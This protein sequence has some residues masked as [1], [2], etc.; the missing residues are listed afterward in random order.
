MGDA[1]TSVLRDYLQEHL[2]DY[3]VPAAWVKLG[4]LP[5]TANGKVDRKAL[6]APDSQRTEL[7]SAYIARRSAI[8]RD[9]AAV[10]QEVLGIEH[11]GINDNFFDLGGH[12]LQAVLTRS[13]ESCARSLKR[14]LLLF[15][16]PFSHCCRD[17]ETHQQR[18]HG[19]VIC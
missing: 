7:S 3:M 8:E 1:E 18:L 19:R 17:G 14:D 12:S 10:W 9:I 13:T 4:A 6:P 15:E 11:V 2:P 16:L 5:L